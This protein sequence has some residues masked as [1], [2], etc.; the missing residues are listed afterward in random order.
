MRRPPV[1]QLN[2]LISIDLAPL[3]VVKCSWLLACSTSPHPIPSCPGLRFLTL[4]DDRLE[5]LHP[6]TSDLI[7]AKYIVFVPCFLISKYR[8]AKLER[9]TNFEIYHNSLGSLR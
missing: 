7:R 6:L 5:I 3:L 4:V 1:P 2:H 9:I 8:N